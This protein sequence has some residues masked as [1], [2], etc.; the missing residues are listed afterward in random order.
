MAEIAKRKN[1]HKLM[2]LFLKSEVL[3]M[4]GKISQKEESVRKK[5]IRIV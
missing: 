2:Q 3:Y 1:L 4:R 5:L